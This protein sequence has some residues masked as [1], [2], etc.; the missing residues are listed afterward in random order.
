MCLSVKNFARMSSSQANYNSTRIAPG[1][2]AVKRVLEHESLLGSGIKKL[3]SEQKTVGCRLRTGKHSCRKNTVK[4]LGK[5]GVRTV[6]LLHLG[7]IRT[8]NNSDAHP[9]G[10]QVGNKRLHTGDIFI[11]HFVFKA[12]KAATNFG[13]YI[14]LSGKI[15]GINLSQSLSFDTM[16]ITGNTEVTDALLVQKR[17]YWVSVS[18]ITPSRSN[19][20]VRACVF[21]S[22]VLSF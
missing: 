20:T 16:T 9:M 18:R 1:L 7:L 3:H 8:R 15:S 11:R 2:Q 19:N 21:V 22:I 14:G 17:V 6:H 13:L 10:T 5:T 12:L 4:L